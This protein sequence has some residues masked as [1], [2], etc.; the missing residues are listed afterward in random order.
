MQGYWLCTNV[1]MAENVSLI[2]LVVT[3]NHRHADTAKQTGLFVSLLYGL[4]LYK[5]CQLMGL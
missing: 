5:M 3:Q 2:Q 4:L 1:C